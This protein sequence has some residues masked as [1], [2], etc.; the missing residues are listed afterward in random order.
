MLIERGCI[1][2]EMVLFHECLIV[3]Y[4][5]EISSGEKRVR[6]CLFA[7]AIHRGSDFRM[8]ILGRLGTK[9]L[10]A[11]DLR[12]KIAIKTHILSLEM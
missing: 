2:R 5:D 3:N 4:L 1:N 10:F 12:T 6:K 11:C 7:I 9:M 8:P